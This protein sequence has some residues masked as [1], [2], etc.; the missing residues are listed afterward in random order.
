[1]AALP[2]LRTLLLGRNQL[3]YACPA[4]C[5]SA[6]CALREE[7]GH[8]SAG[9]GGASEAPAP[10]LSQ[11]RCLGLEGNACMPLPVEAVEHCKALTLLD[12]AGSSAA[13]G[14]DD[15]GRLAAALPPGCRCRHSCPQLAAL[16]PATGQARVRMEYVPPPGCGLPPPGLLEL[17]EAAAA[18]G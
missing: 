11:L 5:G 6:S 18:L 10:Y 3:Q 16:L 7:V 12:L 17:T 8:S 1:M 14:A 4:T 15:W 2:A 9:S 13:A